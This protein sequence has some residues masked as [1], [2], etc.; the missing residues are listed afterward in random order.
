MEGGSTGRERIVSPRNITAPT[1]DPCGTPRYLS[2]EK[3]ITVFAPDSN[4]P[5]TLPTP[6]TNP[7]T[8]VHLVA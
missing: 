4:T 3:C 2:S 6:P 1:T 5:L 8:V 7:L